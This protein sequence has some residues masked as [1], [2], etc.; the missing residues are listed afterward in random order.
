MSETPHEVEQYT[1]QD[2]QDILKIYYKRLFPHAP[3]YRWL[4]YNNGMFLL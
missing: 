1:D 3:F 2:L 4:S